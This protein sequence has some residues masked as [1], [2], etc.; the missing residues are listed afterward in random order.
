MIRIVYLLLLLVTTPLWAE[1]TR[2]PLRIGLTPVFLDHQTSFLEE[3]RGYLESKLQRPVTFAQR[4]SYRGI[5]ELMLQGEL[6]FAWICGYPYVRNRPDL[7]LVAAP[8]YQGEPLYR[9]YLI[10]PATDQTT[11]S[12][13]DLRGRIFAYSD[14]D[15]NSGYLVTQHQLAQSAG[16]GSHGFFRR[17]FF[18]WS[19]RKVVEAVAASVADGGTVDGYVWDTLAMLHPELTARTRVVERSVAFGFPPIVARQSLPAAEIV[20][21]REVLLQMDGDA[22]GRALLARLNLD[23]F[24]VVEP[25]LYQDIE[26]MMVRVMGGRR[27]AQP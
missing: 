24:R 23:G 21:M 17:S 10:V 7:A 22:A 9:A 26:A 14:P 15:S 5:V 1:E 8:L 11:A 16:V 3:W 18:T 20:A 25:A 27:A 2:L 19:H 6:D 12:L 4:S 13:A